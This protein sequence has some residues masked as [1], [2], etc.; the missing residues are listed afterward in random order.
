MSFFGQ[1]CQCNPN[2]QQNNTVTTSYCSVHVEQVL[3]FVNVLNQEARDE[4]EL[5]TELIQDINTRKS[6]RMK[7]LGTLGKLDVPGA[8]RGIDAGHNRDE[9]LVELEGQEK[10]QK[11]R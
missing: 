9:V 7:K 4:V 6:E 10:M 11:D 1:C 3:G 2:T 8:S 5:I